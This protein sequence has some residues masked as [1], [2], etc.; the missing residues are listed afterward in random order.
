[1]SMIS[2]KK[3][4]GIT[5][6]ILALEGCAKYPELSFDESVNGAHVWFN[7]R[8]GCTL[9]IE[10]D[11]KASVDSISDLNKKQKYGGER[12]IIEDYDCDFV[13]DKIEIYEPRKMTWFTWITANEEESYVKKTI[14][15]KDAN[16]YALQSFYKQ[17]LQYIKQR[18]NREV[19]SP[20]W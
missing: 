3:A 17:T 6:L 1:M 13:A 7:S 16:Y 18:N 10:E 19:I 9:T 15:K 11:S 20:P 5:G 2:L 8:N 4:I 12:T 14:T